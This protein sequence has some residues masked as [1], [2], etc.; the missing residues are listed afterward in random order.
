[1]YKFYST[2]IINFF[3]FISNMRLKTIRIEPLSNDEIDFLSATQAKERRA[4]YFGMKIM[5]V[6]CLAMPLF[7]AYIVH[8]EDKPILTF[9]EAYCYAQIIMALIF[10]FILLASYI[11]K[12]LFIDLDLKHQQKIIEGVEI[13]QKKF[14]PQNQRFYF[15]INSR[16]KLSIEVTQ[17]DFLQFVE[18]DEINIEYSQYSKEYFV[19][20]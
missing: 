3:N 13:M 14:M 10:I 19:Y 5:I 4:F 6:V 16:I 20:F 12:L 18:G 9:K 8:F 2:L 15:Y 17:N 11:R 7:V 1:M